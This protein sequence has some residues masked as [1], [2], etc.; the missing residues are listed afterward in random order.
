MSDWHT[1]PDKAIEVLLVAVL[2]MMLT[3]VAMNGWRCI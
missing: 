3:A 1:K 2:V